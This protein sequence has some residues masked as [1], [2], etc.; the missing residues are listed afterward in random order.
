MTFPSNP[1]Q[2]LWI[3]VTVFLFLSTADASTTAPVAGPSATLQNILNQQVEEKHV[4][5]AV[6][7]LLRDGKVIFLGA[8]GVAGD[9]TPMRTDMI[10]RL[11]SI[12]KTITAAAVLMLVEDGKLRLD[13]PVS[14]YIPAFAGARVRAPDKSGRT[15]PANLPKRPVTV[16][17]LLTHQAGLAHEGAE[18]DAAWENAKTTLEFSNMLAM[19]PL[20]FEP[21]SAYEYGPAYEV[22]AA[23]VEIVSN[24]RLDSFLAR[25][26]FEPLGMTDM[27]FF[28]PAEKRLRLSAVY[29]RTSTGELEI[30]RALGQEER[31][32]RFLAGGGGLRGT[33][34][35]YSKFAQ[36]LLNDGQFNGRRLLSAQSVHAMTMNQVADHY[37]S[38]S[39]SYSWGYGVQLRTQVKSDSFGS[40][41]TFGW[42]GGLGT[43]YWVD[44]KERLVGLFFTQ[45]TV[46]SGDSIYEAQD[47]FEAA[48]YTSIGKGQN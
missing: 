9:K 45:M 22:L 12:G 40:V 17:D 25:R 6:G 10:M 28:V 30:D 18:H 32:S 23:I 8:A 33:I 37:P 31:P 11:A 36:M 21:G 20:N 34:S 38:P 2:W 48:I 4:A 27:Y 41:G 35:D 14:K 3:P 43:I 29:K 13:D 42:N 1:T 16:R 19:V 24:E 46:G 15:L 39:H 7:M 5:G 26:I 44:P 47:A